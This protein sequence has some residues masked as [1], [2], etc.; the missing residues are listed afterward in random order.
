MGRAD[1]AIVA[2]R[3]AVHL[4]PT[5]HEAFF[6]LG[7]AAAQAGA[8]RDAAAAFA[9][10]TKLA[11]AFV[12]GWLELGRLR[13]A[14]GEPALARQAYEQATRHEPTDA[15]GWEGLARTAL[16]LKDGAAAL[17]A[18]ERCIALADDPQARGLHAEA[19]LC[20]GRASEALERVEAA[21]ALAPASAPML[22]VRAQALHAL[23]RFGEAVT[24]YQDLVAAFPDEASLLSALGASLMGVERHEEALGVLDRAAARAPDDRTIQNN[25]A[26]ALMQQLR[27]D[28]GMAALRHA[29]ERHPGDAQLTFAL[30]NAELAAGDLAAGWRHYESRAMASVSGAPRWAPGMTVAGRHVL[31]LSEQGLGDAIQFLRY[32]PVVQALGARVSVQVSPRLKAL[33]DGVWP[34]CQVVTEPEAAGRVDFYCP[35]LSL[36]YVLGRPEALP[37]AAPYVR[38]DATR[39]AHWR[40]RLGGGTAP[41]IGLVW[42]GNPAHP[43]DRRRSMPLEVLRAAAPA[44]GLRLVSLQYDVPERDREV[45]ADWSDVMA[46]GTE[47]RDMADTAALIEALDTMICVDTSV[48][49][50]AGALGRPLVL[51]LQRACDWRW[52]LEGERSAWYPSARLVRQ[53]RPGAWAPVAQAAFAAAAAAALPPRE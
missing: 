36:P 28:E 48:A 33:V 38:A 16:Q 15:P 53:P 9:E 22:R 26:L 41:L 51:M 52:R 45:L 50:L 2:L 40:A 10:C 37:M 19:L 14:A 35:L 12:A 27:M 34:G 20:C 18:A 47:Q 8:T 3:H 6:F 29:L 43:D 46:I 32:V 13:E 24:V 11:P 30:A 4:D 21:L 23:G 49:H 42:S 31:L 44:S 17:A 25:R 1:A 39:R 5:S 7:R